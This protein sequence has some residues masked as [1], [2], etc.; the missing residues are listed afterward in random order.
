M[1][2][3][4]RFLAELPASHQRAI[5]RFQRISLPRGASAGE[6]VCRLRSALCR[7]A[8]VRAVYALQDD[9]TRAAIDDLRS[10]RRGLRPND[11]FARYGAVRP[12]RQ[13]VADPRPQTVAEQLFL[14]G[15]L[16]ERPIGRSHAPRWLLPPELRHWLPAPL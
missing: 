4:A 2:H 10:C 9:A 15:W 8:T 13:L 3:W 14:L 6:R 7:P 1:N 12:L 11:L 5:A 16:I